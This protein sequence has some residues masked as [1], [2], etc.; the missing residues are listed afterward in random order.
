MTID[1]QDN[2]N[3]PSGHMTTLPVKGSEVSIDGGCVYEG[4]VIWFGASKGKQAGG[5]RSSTKSFGFIEWSKDGVQQNDMFVHFSN[6]VA[7]DGAYRTLVKGQKV[8]FSIGTN[9]FGERK[10]IFV[11]VVE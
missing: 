7:E 10:A 1:D 9:N 11:K 8:S 4:T 5:N 3:V 2:S 6:I